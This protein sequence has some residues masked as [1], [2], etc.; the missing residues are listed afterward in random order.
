MPEHTC[1]FPANLSRAPAPATGNL[2]RITFLRGLL[3]ETAGTE[4]AVP[5]GAPV[6]IEGWALDPAGDA[7]AD[8]VVVTVGETA[9]RA[10]A[11]LPRSDVALVFRREELDEAG[12]RAT[13]P[14]HEL[15]PGSYAVNFHV[16]DRAAGVYHSWYAGMTFELGP[17][18]DSVPRRAPG[19]IAIGI[20]AV[21][22]ETPLLGRT[23]HEKAPAGCVVTVDGWAVDAEARAPVGDVHFFVDD[24][25]L[26]R[27]LYGYPSEIAARRFAAPALIACGFKARFQTRTLNAGVHSFR[28]VAVSADG[29]VYDQT[30]E[31][32]FEVVAPPVLPELG[33]VSPHRTTARIEHVYRLEPTGE[34]VPLRGT[35]RVERGGNLHLSGWAV[36]DATA[37]A[38]A[39]AVLLVDEDRLFGAFYGAPREDVAAELGSD[40]FRECGFVGAVATTELAP[41]VHTIRCLVRSSNDETWRIGSDV[42]RFEVS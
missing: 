30:D 26:D 28:I 7:G 2:D 38:G 5:R 34:T 11:K 19:R 8:E 6:L 3:R 16:V 36:D 21:R 41:G 23:F 37:A 18:E 14:T 25:T 17:P 33:A 1:D 12:F 32:L 39:N 29:S 42:V 10:R 20:E 13:L 27:A 22:A 35:I 40:A 31:Q 24:L 15:E 9:L 4:R